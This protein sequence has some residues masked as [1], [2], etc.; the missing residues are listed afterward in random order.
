LI[1]ETVQY[2]FLWADLA[3]VATC[4]GRLR[5]KR[6]SAELPTNERWPRKDES[7]SLPTNPMEVLVKAASAM[8]PKQF[9]LPR[10]MGMSIPF[11]GTDKGKSL[12]II[13]ACYS[14]PPS[15]LSNHVSQEKW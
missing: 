4:R 7:T 8:N 12:C 6:E 13:V 1:A 9:E 2:K 3:P 5:G 10:E 15:F 14:V 11:P